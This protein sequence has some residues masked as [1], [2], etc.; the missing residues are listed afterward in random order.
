MAR[1]GLIFPRIADFGDD[2][3]PQHFAAVVEHFNEAR[4]AGARV[5]HSRG[6]LGG[7]KQAYDFPL[8]VSRLDPQFVLLPLGHEF[9][10]VSYAY[11]Q[12]SSFVDLLA[13]RD[14]DVISGHPIT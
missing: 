8:A 9:S 2:L 13:R 14:R 12:R 5:G 1:S 4:A 11:D 6:Q 10:S 7:G 3:L